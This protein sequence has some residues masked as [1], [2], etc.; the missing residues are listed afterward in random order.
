M[1]PG[2]GWARNAAHR[3]PGCEGNSWA[4]RGAVARPPLP[5]VIDTP[6]GRLESSHRHHLVDRY[7]PQASHQVMS[8]DTEIDAETAALPGPQV[9]VAYSYVG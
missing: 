9:S 2:Q 6:L 3:V 1:A 8:T 7:F 4:C 5:V